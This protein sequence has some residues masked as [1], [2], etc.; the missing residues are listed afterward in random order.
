M[1]EQANRKCHIGTRL[2]R[3]TFQPPIPTLSPQTPYPQNLEIFVI[4]YNISLSW[5]RDHF[6]Y[7][8]T[9]TGEYSY[10]GDHRNKCVVRTT[11]YNLTQQLSNSCV[12]FLLDLISL[13]SYCNYLWWRYKARARVT[14]SFCLGVQNTVLVSHV[15][16]S[17]KP[18][19][20]IMWY[21]PSGYLWI[22][23]QIFCKYQ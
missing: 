19:G 9:N 4:Y 11:Q 7:V 20:I 8:A 15:A 3:Y 13:F 1:Y 17:V 21:F 22:I 5:S 6:V 18:C 12:G 2:Y 16:A 23:N 10:R 14:L